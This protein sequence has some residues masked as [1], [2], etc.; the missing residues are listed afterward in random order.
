MDVLKMR[1]V[2]Y[3]T[4]LTA[5]KKVTL[6]KELSVNRPDLE[7]TITSPDYVANFAREFLR[8]HEQ[9]EEYLYMIC[10]NTKNVIHGVFEL[11]HGNVNSSIFGVR[12]IFQKA[13]LANAVSIILLHNHP[14]E[15]PKPSVQDIE[16]T[17]R[18]VEAGRIAGVEVLDHLIIGDTSYVSLKEKGYL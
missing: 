8:L 5:D 17:K 7:K 13:L 6:E 9:S 1:V 18:A 14:S 10:M 3:K 2:K 4:I 12:K 16:S 15:N 11:S